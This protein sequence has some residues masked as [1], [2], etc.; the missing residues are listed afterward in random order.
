MTISS[1]QPRFTACL[2]GQCPTTEQAA[3]DRALLRSASLRE[4]A[5]SLSR[6]AQRL[7]LALAQE[8]GI[9]MT[10]AQRRN[11]LNQGRPAAVAPAVRRPMVAA[12]KGKPAWYG[13]FGQFG[14]TI[15]TAGL[16]AALAIGVFLTMGSGSSNAGGKA[17]GG[18]NGVSIL[19]T[20]S[21]P[22]LS[23]P[24]ARPSIVK[25]PAGAPPSSLPVVPPRLP[26][27]PQRSLTPGSMAART[28][29]LELPASPAESPLPTPPGDEA[30]MEYIRSGNPPVA[31]D[32][33]NPSPDPKFS[34]KA[35]PAG[36][37]D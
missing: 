5:L 6:T 33:A 16:A 10:P 9:A 30:A 13:R 28:P 14:P 35:R 20:P 25:T 36:K 15:A 37:S 3:F 19:P 12:K 22:T 27:G 18:L 32:Y 17:P 21:D 31:K 26:D 2:L 7:T 23:K 34:P 24:V 4:E 8:P 11:V 1:D 29:D